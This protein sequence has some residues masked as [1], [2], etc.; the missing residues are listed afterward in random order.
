MGQV[1]SR[2]NHGP[3]SSHHVNS[4]AEQEKLTRNSKDSEKPVLYSEGVVWQNYELDLEG[5]TRLAW[6]IRSASVEYGQDLSGGLALGLVGEIL[7]KG[8]IAYRF[9]SEKASVRE[10][11]G[12]VDVEG[13]VYVQDLA[14]GLQL[15][16]EAMT[17]SPE[18]QTLRLHGGVAACRGSSFWLRGPALNLVSSVSAAPR[19]KQGQSSN[20]LQ[21]AKQ[22]HK[23]SAFLGLVAP[24]GWSGCLNV[25]G[26]AHAWIVSPSTIIGGRQA[27]QKEARRIVSKLVAAPMVESRPW[28]SKI[29]KPIC[30][31]PSDRNGALLPGKPSPIGRDN[32]RRSAS[33]KRSRQGR[34]NIE[35]Q[36]EVSDG[37]TWD[38]ATD[39]LA[40][41]GNISVWCD[42]VFDR[43]R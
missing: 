13:R 25:E 22:P 29:E 3:A 8:A 21:P 42:K 26:P 41:D 4:T 38:L 24:K 19:R 33:Y 40:S 37:L 31:P 7:M 43:P 5:T 10:S 39:A 12:D 35:I 32:E 14:S 11:G 9:M 18:S 2:S 15:R 17:W 28:T 20:F 34:E 30:A 27:A 36:I 23:S 16:G 1:G 6:H